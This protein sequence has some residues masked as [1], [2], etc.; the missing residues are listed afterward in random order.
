[1]TG[2]GH[3]ET[4]IDIWY[5]AERLTSKHYWVL[6]AWR[7]D[8]GG[9]KKVRQHNTKRSRPKTTDRGE[10]EHKDLM[11]G[12]SMKRHKEAF[13]RA[14]A[15]IPEATRIAH[16][17]VMRDS[18]PETMPGNDVIYAVSRLGEFLSTI[19]D[20]SNLGETA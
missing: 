8:G 3:A 7:Q 4:Q 18:V 6:S 19:S 15:T 11:Q 17:V 14:K 20:Y 1:M 12:A 13:N 9:I 2:S 16:S 10:A 5:R